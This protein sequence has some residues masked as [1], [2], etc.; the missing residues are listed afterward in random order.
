MPKNPPHAPVGAQVSQLARAADEL[1]QVVEGVAQRLGRLEQ[2]AFG[3]D[4]A[5][6]SRRVRKRPLVLFFGRRH[7]ADNSKYLYLHALAR[8]RGYDVLWCTLED[9]L[10]ATLE[11]HGL[12]HL[13]LNRDPDASIDVLL[14][15]A[16]AV[17]TVN[18]HESVGGSFAFRG[19]LAGATQLQL[20]HGVSV[21]H[22]TLQLLPHLGTRQEPLRDPWVASSSVDAVL[23]TS[24]DLDAYW[25]EVFGV[26]QL[27]RA[28]QP[29]NEVLLRD[30]T[31]TELVGADLPAR[32]MAAL[33][34]PDP[35]VLVV[36]TWQRGRTT[37]L[38]ER[39]FLE[40]MVEFGTRHGVTM[41]YKP[42]PVYLPVALAELQVDRLH[43]LDPGI[44]VYPWMFRFG[45]L[46][47]DYSSILFDFLL[48]GNPVLT[49]ELGEH[50]S[51]EPDFGLVPPG[52]P[53]TPFAP[54][55]FAATLAT[56]LAGDGRR[57]ERLAYARRVFASDPAR[58]CAD[59]VPFLDE[60][61][62][63]S[64]RPDHAVWAP[65]GAERV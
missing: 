48:T 28:G 10:A 34:T 53:T 19:A 32:T 14:H 25:R 7:F 33:Q 49:V 46:V 17:F 1:A 36:P 3:E 42:H 65:G 20:W 8:P 58:A 52:L 40:Q 31:P 22:L 63:R 30:A 35:A 62:A 39:R 55:A 4:L 57:E 59:L 23:S 21:K 26:P 51:F 47:T 6:L 24:P 50:Q 64:Q 13:H 37:P 15:A 60:A 29:R 44:D 56:A 9:D 43:V 2:R 27:V 18:P 5:H 16:A 54:E 38:T 45:A 61:V 11:R 12:P 41:V